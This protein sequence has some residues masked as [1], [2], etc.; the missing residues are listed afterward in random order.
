MDC[1][2]G[3]LQSGSKALFRG[4]VIYWNLQEFQRPERKSVTKMAFPVKAEWS[5]A[6][7]FL[8]GMGYSVLILAYTVLSLSVS[9][10][11]FPPYKLH[12]CLAVHKSTVLIRS[13]MARSCS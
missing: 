10:A 12:S 13:R 3:E 7:G 11:L 9:L 4:K 1:G 8:A 6:L 5:E 2:L